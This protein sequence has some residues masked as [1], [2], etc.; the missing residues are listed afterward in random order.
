MKCKGT[1]NWGKPCGNE[2]LPGSDY[3]S[4]HQGQAP[5][6]PLLK[7]ANKPRTRAQHRSL[8]TGIANT[9]NQ[10]IEGPVSIGGSSGGETQ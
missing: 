5:A 3:C 1:N 2:T 10:V 7:P 8:G 9:G 6:D 4:H